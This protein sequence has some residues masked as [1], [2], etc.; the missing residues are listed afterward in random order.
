MLGALA[1]FMYVGG[2]VSIGSFLVNF[3][4]EPSIAGLKEADGAQYVAFYWG[5]AMLG[6][7]VGTVTLRRFAPSRVLAL[8]AL[9]AALCLGG[10]ILLSGHVAMWMLLAVGLFNSIM[11]PTIFTLAIGGLG[12]YTSQGSGI[13]CTAIVGGALIPLAQGALA[14]QI[15]IQHA[16]VIPVVCYAY[17]GWYGLKAM[18]LNR[19]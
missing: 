2:E 3:F 5:G 18:G 4:A 15:G 9:C 17:I 19:K 1:I 11:F 10:A 7:F 12:R 8:H 14:D 16:L 6:R 13:L